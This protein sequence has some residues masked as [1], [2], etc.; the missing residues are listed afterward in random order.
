MKSKKDSGFTLIEL[1]LAITFLGSIV[2]L[3]TLTIVQ[4]LSIY[5]KGVAIKQIG[6][7]GR[8]LID[9]VNR[10]SSGG[11]GVNFSAADNDIAGYLCITPSGSTKT[12]AY[13]WNDVT[14]HDGDTTGHFVSPAGTKVTLARTNDDV[15]AADGSTAY[16][17]LPP[18]VNVTLPQTEIT[19][20]L[21]EQVRILSVKITTDSTNASSLKKIIFWIGTY[22]TTVPGTNPVYNAGTGAWSCQGGRLGDF[23]A[24]GKFETIVYVPNAQ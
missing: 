14:T 24:F 23:C 13:A 9:D 20:L 21:N 12:R 4:S 15:N 1:M 6:Q 5:N 16:C 18:N 11:A 3:A 17:A 22:S 2:L 10:L 19:P 8:T 7:V